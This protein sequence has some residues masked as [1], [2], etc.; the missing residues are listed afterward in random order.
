MFE[1]V[2][3]PLGDDTVECVYTGRRIHAA[4]RTEA[5]NQGFNT[6][7]SWPQSTFNSQ[8]PMVSDL[9]HLFPTDGP[10]NSA[11]SNYPF[12]TVVSNITWQGG[13]S[14]LGHNASGQIV[15]EPR[16]SHKG[17]VARVMLYFLLRYPSNYGTF[18]DSIQE[19]A[20]RLWCRTDPVSQ[21]EVLRTNA[22][23][24]YQG[25]RNPLVDHPEFVD[26]ISYFRT[27]T[28]P[29]QSPDIAV[30]P[31]TINF[32]TVA[33]GDSA[34][35]NL[36][37]MNRGA[38]PLNI[39]GIVLQSA[40]PAFTVVS[41][42]SA[43]PRD[44]F[45]LVHIRFNPPQPNQ[46]YA[47]ALLVQSND[48][49]EGTVS[50]PLSGSAGVT[51]TYQYAVSDGWNLVSVPLTVIDYRRTVVYPS[52][53]SAA[54]AFE[55]TSGYAERDTLTNGVGYWLKFPAEQNIGMTGTIRIRDTVQVVAGWN[56]IG[57][58]GNPVD[59]DSVRQIPDGIV[60]SRYF[61]YSGSYSP[62]D[63][64]QPG[65]GYWVKVNQDGWLV[66]Q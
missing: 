39:T 35:W 43:V 38:V 64:L 27:S 50:V 23:A 1:T 58:S 30:S 42:I 22:I 40:S 46:T 2:D 9:N 17:D 25:K 41:S 53:I 32:G 5:Q 55:R 54:F 13:G 31:R 48:P 24:L 16:D 21:K 65:K 12:G 26:R 47:N 52:A 29:L 20:L 7:H 37:I 57:A 10:P 36:L 49:D 62:A 66:L 19:S 15:F 51:S 33:V 6:E 61:G 45:Q 44:S 60:G 3:D 11:R 59:Q 28:A 18:M 4:T 63:T 8:D 14:K 56:L 34:G